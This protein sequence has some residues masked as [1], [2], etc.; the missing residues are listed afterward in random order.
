M[1]LPHLLRSRSLRQAIGTLVLTAATASAEVR[2]PQ[3]FSSHMVLQ[4]QKPLT[5]WGWAQPE[6]SVTV[7]LA[8]NQRQTKANAQG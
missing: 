4:Q 7:E 8:G 1:T 3:V 5:L 6:E 2:L